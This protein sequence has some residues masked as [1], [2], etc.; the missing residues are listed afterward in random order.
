MIAGGGMHQRKASAAPP[1]LRTLQHSKP[2]E[3][4]KNIDAYNFA[5]SKPKLSTR[6]NKTNTRKYDFTDDD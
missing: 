2:S 3:P 5:M 6:R 1:K 4:S